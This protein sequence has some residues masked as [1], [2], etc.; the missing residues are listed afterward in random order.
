LRTFLKAAGGIVEISGSRIPAIQPAH[1][2]S[3][4]EQNLRYTEFVGCQNHKTKQSPSQPPPIAWR[5]FRMYAARRLFSEAVTCQQR[6]GDAGCN[7]Q[8]G[9]IGTTWCCSPNS[10]G[11]SP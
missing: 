2:S 11:A 7:R 4:Q 9:N 8:R 10:Y 1:N 5:G 3:T 6:Y